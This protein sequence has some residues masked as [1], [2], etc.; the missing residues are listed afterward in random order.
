[1]RE[2]CCFKL[3]RRAFDILKAFFKSIGILDSN[4]SYY[5]NLKEGNSEAP[6][7]IILLEQKF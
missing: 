1:M 3:E 6:M 4:L 5:Y 2:A 7:E